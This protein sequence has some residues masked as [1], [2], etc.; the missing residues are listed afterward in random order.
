MQVWVSLGS[1]G[2]ST[3]GN[4]RL[5]VLEEVIK[6]ARRSHNILRL[7]RFKFVHVV[8][9]VSAENTPCG[10]NASC[11]LSMTISIAAFASPLKIASLVQT[12]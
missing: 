3:C 1:I 5:V 10:T 7:F 9:P 4:A 6:P 8:S 11:E 2:G 12:N